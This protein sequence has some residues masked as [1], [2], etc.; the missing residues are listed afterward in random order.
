MNF[1]KGLMA[2]TIAAVP[3]FPALAEY[4]ENTIT[5]VVP[6]GAGVPVDATA[7]YFAELIREELGATIIV[8]NRGGAGSAIGTEYVARANNDGYTL[9]LTTSSS[10]SV[11]PAFQA[12]I[13]YDPAED[14]EPIFGIFSGGSVL[15]INSSVPA[16]TFEEFIEYA[17]ANPGALSFGSAGLGTIT[18]VAGE[19]FM[20]DT[21]IEMVHV[22]YP[23]SGEAGV[24]LIA[25]HIQVLFGPTGGV[26]QNLQ[27]GE[28]KALVSMAPIR[29]VE[30][31]DLP[32]V[33]ELGHPALEQPASWFGL[34]A[35]AGLPQDARDKLVEAA[36]N[37]FSREDVADYIE[38]F[39]LRADTLMV[40]DEVRALMISDLEA[41]RAIVD[42]RDLG[43]E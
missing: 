2:L 4:P 6:F 7:R 30:L 27:S 23:S 29:P 24:D 18:H 39:G 15:Q 22:P 25:G 31:P 40:G 37:I 14:L 16:D 20:A 8:E 13:G 21:G 42:A 9:L 10:V 12:D 43:I 41:Y 34:F 5:L 33:A 3:A 11:V 35:P 19:I 32:T 36:T 38:R 1:Y 28:V 17:L 26:A